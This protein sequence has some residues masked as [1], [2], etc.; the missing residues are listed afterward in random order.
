MKEQMVIII[1]GATGSLA[2]RLLLPAVYEIFKKNNNIII[3]GT[4]REESSVPEILKKVQE[5]V[6]GFDENSFKKFSEKFFYYMLDINN[7][8]EF[9]GF[10]KYIDTHAPALHNKIIYCATSS[11][12]FLPIVEH[13]VQAH[14]IET[15][16]RNHR[17]IFEKPFGWDAQSA[18]TINTALMKLLSEEQIYRVDHYISRELVNN[19]FVL[20]SAN[21]IFE[22]LWND[23]Y[24]DSITISLLE[25]ETVAGRGAYYD[26]Y[27]ALKDVVQ[28]HLLQMAALVMMELP[29]TAPAENIQKNKA[30]LLN[31]LVFDNGILGQYEGYRAEQDVAPESTTET[32]AAL[33]LSVNNK[34]WK[35]S[36]LFLVTGKALDKKEAHIYIAFKA[37]PSCF[38]NDNN[39]CAPNGLTIKI[40]PQEGFVLHVNAKKPQSDHETTRVP[41]EFCYECLFGPYTPQAY[42]VL[43]S[44]VMR[45]DRSVTVSIEEIVAQWH[46]IDS[47]KIAH[48]PLYFYK[49]N[50]HGPS[51]TSTVLGENL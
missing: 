15:G 24:I 25:T 26:H 51:E 10:S 39:R 46:L 22:P 48:L 36:T 34:R 13:T 43:L 41:L 21:T 12:Y 30:A 40:Y 23:T 32:Y 47:V 2:T 42:E 44:K 11:H 17:V 1:F 14:I 19:I 45:N 49:K 7:V 5:H 20:R 28:N 16:T 37:L 9:D 50:S 18:I 29:E 3:F 27:G 31:S 35:K 38:F 6:H 33:K 8:Q 4:A